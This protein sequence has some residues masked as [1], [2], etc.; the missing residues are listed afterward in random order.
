MAPYSASIAN[1]ETFYVVSV[2]N[3]AKNVDMTHMAEIVV[4]SYN[5]T[6]MDIMHKYI[7]SS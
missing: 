3:C 4:K 2:H 5:T 7:K 1:N 6:C